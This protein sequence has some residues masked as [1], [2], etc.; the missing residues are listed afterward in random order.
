MQ[1]WQICILCVVSEMGILSLHLRNMST[2]IQIGA[3]FTVAF[4]MEHCNLRDMG[5]LMLHGH[6]RRSV[7][8]EENV[9]DFIHD[10]PSISP[11]YLLQ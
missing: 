9:L 3:N 11:Q 5:P 10:N 2:D 1:G 6:G 8:G 7:Q 4:E